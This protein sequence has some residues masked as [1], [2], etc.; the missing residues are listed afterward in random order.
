M[1]ASESC[2][3]NPLFESFP[4]Y[5]DGKPQNGFSF[6]PW[7]ITSFTA[8]ETKTDKQTKTF[9]I[10]QGQQ[11]RITMKCQNDSWNGTLKFNFSAI[12]NI[13]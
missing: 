12:W 3:D 2:N 1:T 8:G 13:V 9:Y 11:Y 10:E 7:G 4:D 5:E 6:H